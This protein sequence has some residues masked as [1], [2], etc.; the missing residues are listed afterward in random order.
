MKMHSKALEIGQYIP[1]HYHFQ[2]LS[3]SDR[4]N[5]FKT[6]ID[7]AVKPGYKV[8]ELGCGTGVMSYLAA[9]KGAQVW[10]VEYNPELVSASRKFISENNMSDKVKIYHG[11][12]TNWLPPEPVDLVICEMLHSALLR[13]K[14]VKVIEAFRKAHHARFGSIPKFMP[15]ATLLA[16]QPVNQLYD[17]Y[18]YY[19]PVPFFQSAY[20]NAVDCE[21]LGD[22][23]VYKIV[24]YDNASEESYKSK[25][26]IVVNQDSELNALRFITKSLMSM[27]FKTGKTVD[28]HNQHLVLPLPYT[29]NVKAGQS[30][31]L[32]FDYRPGDSIDILQNSLSIKLKNPASTEKEF[33]IA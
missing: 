25:V 24:D 18:G 14:Q 26:S 29:Y 7:M 4:M 15:N 9:S 20:H 28:W 13:E 2:M 32:S 23:A 8:A 6:A 5:S 27:D 21:A 12:A 11:D 22:P 30:I 10:S 33:L 3:D 1:I 31:N 16:V 17:F 19:A